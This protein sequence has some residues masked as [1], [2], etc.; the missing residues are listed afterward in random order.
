MCAICGY[1]YSEELGCPQDGIP[2]GTLWQDVPEDWSC[3]ECGVD[4]AS[5]MMFELN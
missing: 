4:K 3:P 2:P 1:I 5:F